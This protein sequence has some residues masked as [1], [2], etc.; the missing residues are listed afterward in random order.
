MAAAMLAAGCHKAGAPSPGVWAVVNGTEIQRAEVEKYYRLRVNPQGPAPSQ[1][2]S[3]S[4]MLNILDALINNQIL[5]QRAQKLGLQASDGEVEDKFTE[6]KSPYTEDEFQRQLQDQHLTVDDLKNDIR[7]EL[8]IQKLINREVV[9]KI[10]ITDQDVAEFYSQNRQQFDHP[11]T[12][13][14]LAQIVV[15]PRKDPEVRNRRNDDATTDVEARRKIAALYQKLQ[16]GADFAEIAMDYSEDPQ[17]TTSGGDMGFIPESIIASDP[18]L[19]KA[20]MGLQPG[21]FTGVIQFKDAYRII[22]LI[23]KQAPGQRELSD[24][25]VQQTIREALRSRKQ[26]LLQAAY[27]A[28]AR[29]DAKVVNY[30]AQQVMESNG[31]LPEVSPPSAA[32]GSSPAPPT[33]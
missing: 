26:Q 3:L 20:V 15:T 21:Q 14:E 8:S 5:L 12:R 10:T 24:P 7:E 11:E 22:K 6:S 31:R 33:P 17:T 30:L 29:D 13:Y 16:A 25:E 28:E 23:A 4:L 32:V 18:D 1:E 27:L 19:K 9:S 2:E